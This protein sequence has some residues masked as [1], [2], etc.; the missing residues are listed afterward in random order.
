MGEERVLT[1]SEKEEEE[2]RKGGC[3]SPPANAEGRLG[4]LGG[5]G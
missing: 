3:M 2:G 1:E 5:I 4:L